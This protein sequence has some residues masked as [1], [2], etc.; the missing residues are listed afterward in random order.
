MLTE[1]EQLDLLQ[2]TGINQVS[3]HTSC[4]RIIIFLYQFIHA[5]AIENVSGVSSTHRKSGCL[6]P[7]ILMYLGMMALLYEPCS[8]PFLAMA[9]V[10]HQN[11]ATDYLHRDQIFSLEVSRRLRTSLK[12]WLNIM[13]I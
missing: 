8:I 6:T 7:Q 10:T 4:Q 3:N 9:T 2:T 13:Q 5:A 12:C 11:T 1:S